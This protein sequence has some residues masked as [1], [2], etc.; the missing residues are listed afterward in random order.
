MAALVHDVLDLVAEGLVLP[1]HRLQLLL[2]LLVHSLHLEQLRRVL[3]ALH[4]GLVK[5][6]LDQKIYS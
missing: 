1:A 4:L 2:R 6:S 5:L 3:A